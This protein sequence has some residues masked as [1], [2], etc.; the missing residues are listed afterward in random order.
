MANRLFAINRENP[1]SGYGRMADELM[2]GD[3]MQVPTWV[4]LGLLALA[5]PPADQLDA[6]TVG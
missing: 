2:C 5:T 6:E 4:A 1:G 3:L